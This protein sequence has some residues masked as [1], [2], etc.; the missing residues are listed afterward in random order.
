MMIKISLIFK[1]LTKTKKDQ[2]KRE[3]KRKWTKRKIQSF[4]NDKILSILGVCV[5]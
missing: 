2:N 4:R 5:Y 3:R 1:I